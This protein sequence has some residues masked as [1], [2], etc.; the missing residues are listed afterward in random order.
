MGALTLVSPR[1]QADSVFGRKLWDWVKAK[2]PKAQFDLT[3]THVKLRFGFAGETD[4]QLGLDCLTAWN[5]DQ[6]RREP[7]PWIYDSGVRYEREILCTHN[8]VI[9][10]CEEW[11]TTAELLKRGSGDCEDLGCTTA[12]MRI[13]YQ[14]EHARAFA[15]RSSVGWHIQVKRADGS[16]E[17]PSAQLGMNGD[18]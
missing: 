17:D 7:F 3:T 2:K 11:W 18:G 15:K 9:G 4:L 6:C 5:V 12:A 10:I 1:N 13:V 8:G 14:K 16:I